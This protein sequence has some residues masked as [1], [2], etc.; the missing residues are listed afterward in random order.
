MIINHQH[1]CQNQL[2][3]DYN[4]RY[5]PAKYHSGQGSSFMKPDADENLKN[6]SFIYV[7]HIKRHYNPAPASICGILSCN[8]QNI[9]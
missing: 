6:A 9:I 1:D 2:I 5:T 7:L 3:F 8:Y 4:D